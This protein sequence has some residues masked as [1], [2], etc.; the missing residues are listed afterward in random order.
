MLRAIVL[1]LAVLAGAKIW[2]QDRLYRDGAEEA[3]I[4]AYR[5]RAIAACQSTYMPVSGIAAPLWTRPSTVDLVIGRSNV[6]VRFWQLANE[7]W[8][9]R[10]K[11]PHVVLTLA[12]AGAAPVCEYDVI[13]ER[14][15]VTQM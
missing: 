10:F 11:H 4:R 12:N 7:R 14:A 1:T 8:P 13:E 15:Y 2:V 6:D 3:L 9:L 5:E